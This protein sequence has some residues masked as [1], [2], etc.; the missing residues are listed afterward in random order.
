MP[1]DTEVDPLEQANAV[2]VSA[3]MSR[4]SAAGWRLRRMRR[5]METCAFVVL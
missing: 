5:D 2:A 1:G 3:L 4:R